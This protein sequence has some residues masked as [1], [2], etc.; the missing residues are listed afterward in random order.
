MTWGVQSLQAVWF[1]TGPITTPAD[2]LY[3]AMVG[4]PASATQNLPVGNLALAMGNVGT[5][6]YRIQVAPARVDYFLVPTS[7]PLSVN[8][9]MNLPTNID[10]EIDN[11]IHQVHSGSSLIGDAIRLALVTNISHETPD[12]QASIALIAP[13]IGLTIPFN[14]GTDLL[15]QINRR[16]GLRSVAGTEVNRVMKWG[17]AEVQTIG[18]MQGTAPQVSQVSLASVTT[19]IN[20]IPTSRLYLPGEQMAIFTEIATETKRLCAAKNLGA[21]Q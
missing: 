17:V 14:D 8:A 3:Q 6:S 4:T 19:D 12:T 9:S 15:V 20:T 1:T 16:L 11:F 5:T 18:V 21:L 2:A 7:P 13:H 10:L